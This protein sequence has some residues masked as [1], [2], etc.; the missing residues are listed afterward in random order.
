MKK[1]GRLATPGLPKPSGCQIDLFE[2]LSFV[3]QIDVGA[4]E[5][6]PG[7]GLFVIH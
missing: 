7:L 3:D 2:Q 1:S 5:A 6:G 4:L